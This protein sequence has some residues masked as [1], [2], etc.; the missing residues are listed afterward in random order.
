M[1]CV[2]V[3]GLTL[4]K[5]FNLPLGNEYFSLPDREREMK[6]EVLSN[7]T[8]VII[9]EMSMVKADMLYQLHLRFQEI[10]QNKRDFGGVSILLLGDLMQ[11]PPPRAAQIFETPKGPKFSMYHKI[12]PLWN[13]FDPVEL[14]TNHRQGSDKEFGDLLNRIREKKFTEE[15]L[16]I[17]ASRRC[18]MRPEGAWCVYGKND[19]CDD[20]NEKELEK[21]PGNAEVMNAIHI[22]R[23][24]NIEKNI[25]HNTG[26]LDKLRLKKG[27]RIMLVHNIDTSDRMSNGTCGYVVGFKWSKGKNPEMKNILVQFDDPRSGAKLRKKIRD[28]CALPQYATIYSN[29]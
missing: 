4:N 27:A 11:L 23:K 12:N 9:D 28:Q 6:R 3:D 1:L 25:I 13:L 22:G 14:K 17:L 19:P 16:K 15:D 7:L 8:V 18:E 21:L 10:K 26:F 24:G 2:H 5:A 20:T 29:T